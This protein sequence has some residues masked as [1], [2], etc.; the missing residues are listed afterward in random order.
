MSLSSNAVAAVL[1]QETSEV[2]LTLAEITHESLD[3]PL[4]FVGNTENVLHDGNTYYAVAFKFTP[5]TSSGEDDTP[6]RL[7][8]DNVDR[9]VA[10]QVDPISTPLKISFK[11]VLA[12]SPDTVEWESGELILRNV[13]VN[14]QQISGSLY[15]VYIA[16]RTVPG[17][18]FSPFDFPG[19]F[20]K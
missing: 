1:A 8:I 10:E 18:Y 9:S 20:A 6:A 13:R 2:F 4:R 3:A 17:I 12:S 19:L 14:V 7:A 16:D 15:D 5:P 11:I